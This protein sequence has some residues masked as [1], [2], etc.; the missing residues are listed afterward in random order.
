MQ[1]EGYIGHILGFFWDNGK[2]NGNYYLGFRVKG[3]EV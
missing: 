3:S 1:G 2:Y